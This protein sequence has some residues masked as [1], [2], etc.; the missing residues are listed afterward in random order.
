MAE[1]NGDVYIVDFR[2]TAFSRSR[3]KEPERDVFNS[4]RMDEALGLLIKRSVERLSINPSEVNDVIVGCALQADENW[5]Y[6]GRHPVFMAGMPFDVPS[7]AIDRACSSSMN[8]VTIGAMEIMTGNADVVMAG[9]MEHMTHVPLADN[10]HIKPNLKL[11]LRPEY[12]KYDMN[13][14]YSM[15]L[16]AEKLASL[17]KIGR[18]EMDEF[19]Y[20]SHVKAAKAQD[21]GFFKGEIEPV[22]VE[23]GNEMVTVD[24]DQSVRRNASLEEM[25]KLRPAF[26]QEGVI[27]A[28]NSSPLNAGASLVTLMSGKKAE[29]HSIRPLAR[30]RSFAWAAVDPTIMGHGPVPASQKALKKAGL[31]V[32]DVD[33]WEINEAF[34]VVVLNAIKELNIDP[35]RVN[36]HG[37][38]IAIGH[39][40]G[41]TGARIV[42][43]LARILQEKKKDI[44]VA[45]LCVGGGQGYTV[46]IERYS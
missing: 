19:S 33:F 46:V 37:G 41:A 4:I 20:N 30:I 9:G 40:L 28:G 6:G 5:L 12:R 2:R 10:P 24:T 21:E 45:T 35:S 8:A 26:K 42:G 32:D 1:A 22:Q 16:T 7:M 39:P 43:T 18:D 34:A 3:P 11:L 14:S 15:G 31:S 44:G 13:T 36:V 17:K 38:A 27:T 25:K 23:V 29:E